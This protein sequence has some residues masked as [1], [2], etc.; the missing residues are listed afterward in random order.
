MLSAEEGAAYSYRYPSYTV[1]KVRDGAIRIPA[2][3][4]VPKGDIETV[5]FVS[6]WVHLKQQDGTV[7]RL[8]NYWML[9]GVAEPGGR[10]WS[11]IRD[12]LGW[13]E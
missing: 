9:G 7:D 2:V 13:I 4:S 6:N 12:M 1:V 8:Y 3:Y 10:R 11:I 5:Q